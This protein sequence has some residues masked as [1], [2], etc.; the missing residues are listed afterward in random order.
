LDRWVETYPQ[1]YPLPQLF[2]ELN[3]RIRDREDRIGPSHLLRPEDLSESDLLAI[4]TESLLPLLEERHL[5]TQV[6]V[7]ARFA[8]S[9]LMKEVSTAKG[10]DDLSQPA[11]PTD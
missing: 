1:T 6:D 5:G 3:S 11:E 8:L 10:P 4:W 7:A 2:A 9:S